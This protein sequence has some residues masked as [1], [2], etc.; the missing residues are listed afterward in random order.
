MLKSVMRRFGPA[1]NGH[2][3]PFT[4]LE[5]LLEEACPRVQEALE[6]DGDA[7]PFLEAAKAIVR[8]ECEREH[9]ETPDFDDDQVQ[10]AIIAY[11]RLLLDND[12]LPPGGQLEEKDLSNT[13][14]LLLS[15]SVGAEDTVAD[16]D[17][18]LALLEEK[19][20]SGKF[21]QAA[22]LLRLFDT[23]PARER[24]NERTLF[25]EEM[26]SRFGVLRL[27]RIGAGQVRKYKEIF[28]GKPEPLVALSEAAVWLGTKAGVHLNLALRNPAEQEDW[29]AGWKKIPE[30]NSLAICRELVPPRRWRNGSEHTYGSLLEAID[31]HIDTS[32]VV[33]YYG[34]LLKVCYFIVLVTGKTGFE[35]YIKS[36]FRWVEENFGFQAST[37]LPDL[38]HETTIGE[39]GLAETV[40]EVLRA[41]MLP[42]AAQLREELEEDRIASALEEFVDDLEDLDPNEIPPGEY[43]LAGLLL[44]HLTG[45]E[46]DDRLTAFRIH[47]I[48]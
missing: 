29:E 33:E 44:D 11:F 6:A 24:N 42:H 31:K 5:P 37:I 40:F 30:S 19:F 14:T 16:S 22:I 38:H 32:T 10:G 1:K 7:D 2:G 20:N 4:Y 23:T 47:R 45:L 26:F 13:R 39:R 36:Y 28:K 48:C 41:R 25:Y 3:R 21:T 17:R 43:D 27:N 34:H 15:A 46:V 8:I 9:F 35:P 18:V 12:A